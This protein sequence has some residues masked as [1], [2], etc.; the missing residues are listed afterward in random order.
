MNEAQ[1]ARELGHLRE[2]TGPYFTF[3]LL[4]V[5]A[6]MARCRRIQVIALSAIPSVRWKSSWSSIWGGEI[7]VVFSH[8]AGYQ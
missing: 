6:L 4:D 8:N 2:I 7:G 1:T 3:Q 5:F